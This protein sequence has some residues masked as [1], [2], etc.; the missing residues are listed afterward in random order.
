MSDPNLPGTD[1]PVLEASFSRRRWARTVFAVLAITAGAYSLWW[2]WLASEVR[3]ELDGWVDAMH[4]DGRAAVYGALTVSG[5][6]GPLRIGIVRLDAADPDGGWRIRVPELRAELRP[7]N[8]DALSGSVAGPLVLTLDK[9]AMPGRYILDAERNDFTL[10]RDQGGRLRIDLAGVSAARP[11]TGDTLHVKSLSVALRRGA[12]PVYGQL[13]IDARDASLPAA[14][15]SAFGGDVAVFRVSAEATGAAPPQGI[16]AESL[17]VWVND[18]GAVDIRALEIAHGVLGMKG[19]GTLAL[20]G[21]LQPIGAFTA[22]ISGFNEAVD[23]LV[24]AGAARPQDG[25][26]AKVVLG[27]LAKSPPGGGAKVVSLP[28]SLQ[29]RKLSVG[30]VPLIRLKTIN[31][32]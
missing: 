27:V 2:S 5:Y 12:L 32:Q 6:P 26:L 9:G 30:P 23:A 18:G 4:A 22:G 10:E 1:E 16:D 31:W 11:L 13:R 7:W 14:M 25:A 24:A 20:D 21:D 28:L 29:D 8:F 17:R 15:H 19:E 3:A